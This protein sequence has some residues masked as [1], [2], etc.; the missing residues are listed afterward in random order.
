[1]ATGPIRMSFDLEGISI[2]ESRPLLCKR[3]AYFIVKEIIKYSHV[4][5]SN[6]KAVYVQLQRLAPRGHK[7]SIPKRQR[8][9]FRDARL[10]LVGAVQ[11]ASA[12][13][14]AH[15]NVVEAKSFYI[16]IRLFS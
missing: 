3:S 13:V 16:L 14:F 1:M 10:M 9:P 8:T 6:F 2:H 5:N 11:G 15:G 4:Y 7:P 12:F